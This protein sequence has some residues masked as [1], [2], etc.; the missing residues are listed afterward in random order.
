M[1]PRALE[2]AGPLVEDEDLMR[3]LASGSGSAMDVLVHRYHQPLHGYLYRMTMNEGIAADLV[4]ESFLAIYRE[5]R[6]GNVPEKLKPWLYRIA[7]N[8]CKDYWKKSS[9]RRE[10]ALE[11]DIV[12]QAGESAATV[13]MLEL[14]VERQWM[15]DALNRLQEDY[16][17]VLFLRF[18][19]DLTYEQIAETLGLPLNTVK[20][21]MFRGLKQLESIIGI[22]KQE[23]E[24]SGLPEIAARR[25]GRAE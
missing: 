1:Q 13:N 25:K 23:D 4:Q 2:G 7:T 14:Q 19:Q 5:A 10:I 22:D 9:T 11:P 3:E 8:L 15:L 16:R 24:G 21:R 17:S 12:E 20:S 18:Y 6:R